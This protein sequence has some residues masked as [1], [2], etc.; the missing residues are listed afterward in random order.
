MHMCVMSNSE[1]DVL[2]RHRFGAKVHAQGGKCLRCSAAID[3]E[4]GYH[5]LTCMSGGDRA[6]LHNNVRDLL[7]SLATT[8]L[9]DP[10]RECHPFAA[11]PG[12]RLDV[13]FPFKGKTML[14]D[15]A[16]THALRPDFVDSAALTSGGAANKY[17]WTKFATYGGL[18]NQQTQVLLPFVAETFGAWSDGA[19]ETIS[20]VGRAYAARTNS[21]SFGQ[22]E[23]ATRLNHAVM[24]GV[25]HLL[26]NVT[27]QEEQQRL[28][29]GATS[30]AG[31][32]DVANE[33]V[34]AAP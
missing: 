16:I 19:L 30:Q 8:G 7:F 31:L 11:S 25:A 20:I 2:V 5:S 4:D 27:P 24:R 26:F 6:I 3:R 1:F 17:S 15:V 21:G 23:V 29:E 9:L 12:S 34:T 10:Q 14:V 22:W 33:Q 13:G 28:E 18:V 32:L